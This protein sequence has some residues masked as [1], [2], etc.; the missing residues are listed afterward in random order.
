MKLVSLLTTAHDA[1]THAA[2]N[3]PFPLANKISSAVEGLMYLAPACFLWLFAG[4][5]IVELQPMLATG[6]LNVIL[7]S[8]FKFLAAAMLGFA[9][10]SLVGSASGVPL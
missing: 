1:S 6:A 3:T 7:A 8:P 10:N 2:A 4:S 5:M 9:V